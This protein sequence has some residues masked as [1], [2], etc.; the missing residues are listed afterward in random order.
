MYDLRWSPPQ[1]LKSL[2]FNSIADLRWSPSHIHH[3][4]Q[5]HLR[6]RLS[7]MRDPSAMLALRWSPSQRL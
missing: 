6:W 4:W 5:L 1:T 3:R 7:Q 2:P